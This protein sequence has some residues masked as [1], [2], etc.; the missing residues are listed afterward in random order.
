VDQSLDDEWRIVAIGLAEGVDVVEGRSVA[1]AFW[2]VL[3]DWIRPRVIQGDATGFG[4]ARVR[5][6]FRRLLHDVHTALDFLS[7][8]HLERLTQL[9]AGSLND[10]AFRGIDRAEGMGRIA[11][12]SWLELRAISFMRQQSARGM[13]GMPEEDRDVASLDAGEDG[14]LGDGLAAAEH[15]A[16]SGSA[17]DPDRDLLGALADGRPVLE[18]DLE[19]VTSNAIIATA[20]L[21]LRR[22]LDPGA[23]STEVASAE[24]RAALAV[25]EDEVEV[26]LDAAAAEHR[27]RIAALHQ[28]RADHPG[29]A[30]RTGEGIDRQIAQA[31]AAGLLWPISGSRVSTLFGLARENAGQKRVS[32]YRKALADLLPALATLRGLLGRDG[33]DDG[34]ADA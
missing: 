26:A 11:A 24:M 21:Q 32:N 12:T 27:A 10:P 1:T 28:R 18:L 4:Q 7:H 25:P 9:Q 30:I 5:P 23:A 14:G 6:R 3:E 2:L 8:I 13:V 16:D 20:G 22:R 34:K 31:T 19:A 33:D 29:M 17:A 15:A